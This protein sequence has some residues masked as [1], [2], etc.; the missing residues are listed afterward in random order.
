MRKR[1]KVRTKKESPAV[2]SNV[3]RQFLELANIHL[4]SL[5][6]SELYGFIKTGIVMVKKPLT[7]STKLELFLVF[8]EW[9]F[10]I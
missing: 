2:F 9:W 10:Y 7:F 5:R 4:G 1:H 6:N 3:T 8:D